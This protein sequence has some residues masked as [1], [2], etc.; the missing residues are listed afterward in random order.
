MPAPAIEPSGT[1][2]DRLC[3]QPEQK[4]GLAGDGERRRA[5]AHR[6][7]QGHPRGDGAEGHAP[8]DPGGHDLGDAIGVQLA[9]GGHEGAVLEVPLADDAGMLGEVIED[10]ADEDL[11]EGALLLDDEDLLQ[12]PRELAHDAG[13]HREEHADAQQADAV[14]LQGGV[15]Q[16]QLEECLA[17][18]VVG[19][20]GGRD[21]EPRIARG[22]GDGVEPVGRREDLGRLQAPVVDVALHLQA[23]GRQQ[24]SGSAC[25]ARAA[26]RRGRPGSS[27]ATRSGP[28]VAV[29]IS[30]A[31]LVTIFKP[32]PQAR[33]AR[34]L[35]AEPA[36]IEDLLH[37]AREEHGEEG[38]VEGHLGVD[39]QGR[40]LGQRIVAPQGQHAAVPPHPAVVGVLEGVAAAVDAG[41]LA[42]PHAE[43]AVVARLGKMLASWLPNTTVAREVLVDAGDEADVVLA[44]Q[45]RVALQRLIEARRAASRG[46]P[47]SWWPC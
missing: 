44:Q 19:L 8:L 41:P 20:A 29:P 12:A 2:V 32:D 22:D 46:S 26:P 3:G 24:A 14:V 38:V 31:T 21:A 43:D 16:P 5:L 9:V 23:E 10:V 6:L 42:V 17:Q 30:S 15:V 4:N 37:V 1:T 45:L 18:V 36:E 33:V 11:H 25:A 13:L 7:Q 34:Q 39:G 35:E 47:R 27:M 28:T 40:R